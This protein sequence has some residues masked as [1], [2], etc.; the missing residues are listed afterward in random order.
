MRS[1]RRRLPTGTARRSRGVGPLPSR[2][3]RPAR[4]LVARLNA[5]GPFGRAWRALYEVV[6]ACLKCCAAFLCIPW[7]R[8]RRVGHRANL[9][10]R[11]GVV[12]CP[13]HTSYLDP[14]F[15]QL[16][17]RRRVTFLMTSDFYRS[18]WGNWFFRLVGAVPVGSP[19]ESRVGLRRAIALVRRG[20][21]VVIFP[22]GR[23][24]RDGRLGA[25]HRG[26]GAIARR[27]GAPVFPVGIVGAFQAWPHGARRP[28][29]AAVRLAFGH[30]LYWSGPRPLTAVRE[31]ERAFVARLRGRVERLVRALEAYE[32]RRAG[33]PAP[34]RLQGFHPAGR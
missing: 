33:S 27:T 24:S 25:M 31:E 17:V 19:R 10:R 23:L 32:R 22:E 3:R 34:P 18:R 2:R 26:V 28:H 5:P 16:L 15:V 13:N 6:Y 21:A 20:H 14:A 8:I 30:P 11:G 4:R 29:R 9:P 1:P 12:L 7:F